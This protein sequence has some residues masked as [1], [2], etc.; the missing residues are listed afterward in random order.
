MTGFILGHPA[1]QRWEQNA[2]L[3]SPGPLPCLLDQAAS[4]RAALH[5]MLTPSGKHFLLFEQLQTSQRIDSNARVTAF[6]QSL[7]GENHGCAVE[8]ESFG[9]VLKDPLH[10]QGLCLHSTISQTPQP[11][12]C[13]LNLAVTTARSDLSLGLIAPVPLNASQSLFIPQCQQTP[14]WYYPERERTV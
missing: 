7:N 3:L 14:G 11:G 13:I 9:T 4:W 8:T 10:S 5:Q 2:G 6:L 1:G 12:H